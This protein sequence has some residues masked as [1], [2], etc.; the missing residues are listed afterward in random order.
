MEKLKEAHSGVK[1]VPRVLFDGWSKSDYLE[2]F[3]DLK[4][5]N[6][7]GNVLKQQFKVFLLLMNQT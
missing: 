1:I 5:M 4:H 2:L 6:S 3:S 7:L